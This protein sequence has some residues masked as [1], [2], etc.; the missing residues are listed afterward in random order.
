MKQKDFLLIGLIVFF[1]AIFAI[2]LSKLFITGEKTIQTV[3][4]VQP[5][6]AEF[7]AVDK[8]YFN[9]DAFNPT[10]TIE[11]QDNENTAPFNDKKSQ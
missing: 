8:K 6:S 11:I 1:G 2:G 9:A 5:I 10:L 3:E 4:V 7:P